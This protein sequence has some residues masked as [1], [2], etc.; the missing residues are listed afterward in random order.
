MKKDISILRIVILVTLSFL[1]IE[2]IIGVF[3]AL[4]DLPETITMNFIIDLFSAFIYIWILHYAAKG[5]WG[6]NIFNSF[7][8]NIGTLK[9]FSLGLLAIGFIIAIEYITKP[10]ANKLPKLE[11]F[12]EIYSEMFQVPKNTY[13]LILLFLS[14]TI[15]TAI[16]EE[17]FFRGF[18]YKAL[19]KKYNIYI[20]ILI[21]SIIFFLFHL[22]PQMLIFVAVTNIILCLAFE[23]GKSLSLPVF[24]HTGINAIT[25][26][27]F[28]SNKL[29]S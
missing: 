12:D 23:Y 11:I 17:L 26:V 16:V 21:L 3:S 10:I 9:T 15:I 7:N 1:V 28:L 18:L 24:I 19:R 6:E 20:S 5:F 22:N 27:L 4:F 25:L 2:I 13:E 14:T 29:K 8:N